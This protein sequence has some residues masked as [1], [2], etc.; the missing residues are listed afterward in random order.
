VTTV[1]TAT[2]RHNGTGPV[3]AY[4]VYPTTDGKIT[5]G[6]VSEEHLW[7]ATCEALG[8]AHLKDI[9]FLA[10]LKQVKELD[11]EIAAALNTMTTAEA[12]ARLTTA[13][14]PVAPVLTRDEMLEHPHFQQRGVAKGSPIRTT[15]HPPLPPGPISDLDQHHH[16]TWK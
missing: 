2:Q 5:L 9:D 7:K 11:T 13:G 1:P 15:V 16:E 8:L 12:L 3:P 4:G 6:V 10:R 14:A